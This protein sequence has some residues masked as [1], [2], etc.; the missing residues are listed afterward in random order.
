MYRFA[1]HLSLH[2][3]LRTHSPS[4]MAVSLCRS[5]ALI[6]ARC[7][8]S[9]SR[10]INKPLCLSACLASLWRSYRSST[11]ITAAVQ[12]TGF[13]VVRTTFAE[14]AFK[15]RRLDK[16]PPI[17]NSI[18]YVNVECKNY[19]AIISP[20]NNSAAS[21]LHR[22]SFRIVVRTTTATDKKRARPPFGGQAMG[23]RTENQAAWDKSS[24]TSSAGFD[25]ALAWVF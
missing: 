1:R 15:C 5:F 23:A 16:V 21:L 22:N 10:F 4:I 2:S 6:C 17:M 19:L 18:A 9:M 11:R 12:S 3:E 8:D 25:P 24:A 7:G 13:N 20:P 14:P